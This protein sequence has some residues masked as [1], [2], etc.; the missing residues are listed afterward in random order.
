MTK[1]DFFISQFPSGPFIGD[2]AA[3]LG[4]M[5]HPCV[6]Q[7]AFFE[8]VHFKRAWMSLY[9]IGRKAMLVNLSDAVAMNA[10]PRYALL[11][12]AMPKEMTRAEM[13][14][15]ARGLRETA[16]R[17]GVRIVGGDTVANVKLD[18]S[19]TI[20]AEC[21]RPLRRTGIREG[22]L[23]AHTG[24]L[25]TVAR[26]LVKL[27]KG[28][29]VSPASRFRRPT[30]RTAFMRRA[31]PHLHA[32]MDISDGLFTDLR[33]LHEANGL[34]FRFMKPI[35]RSIGCSGEEYELL[36]AFA[37]RELQAL[38]RIAR[39]TRTPLT[40]F[41]RAERMPYRDVCKPQHF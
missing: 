34:G 24:R 27:L 19:V 5:K 6:S 4:A 14:E 18:I 25:G 20:L 33:R 30:V 10:M 23:L 37:P 21:P 28:H 40:V 36:I 13:A 35:P 3:L 32:A 2:D 22:D 1:E 17:H 12:V 41:A 11:T 38:R 15:L 7:D 31:A 26:D 9:E 8:D 29:P 39:A 16:E